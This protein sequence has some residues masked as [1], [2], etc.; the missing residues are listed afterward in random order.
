MGYMTKGQFQKAEV[1]IKK[2]AE[3]SPNNALVYSNW[4]G[5]YASQNNFTEAIKYFNKA[6]ELT[7]KNPEILRHLMMAY[8]QIGDCKN[9][10][11]VYERPNFESTPIFEEIKIKCQGK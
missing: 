6:L 2:A 10:L 7:P 9:A 5:I 8:H 4:G 3:Y 1:E 11:E